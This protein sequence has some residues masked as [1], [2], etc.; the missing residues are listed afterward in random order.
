M[1][2]LAVTMLLSVLALA[3][4]HASEQISIGKAL[5]LV[6]T[7]NPV[8]KQAQDSVT[9]SQARLNGKRSGYYPVISV[10][11]TYAH[12]DPDPFV[13]FP[14]FGTIQFFPENSYDAHASLRQ[15]LWD[16][17]KT[18]S[19]AGAAKYSFEAARKNFELVKTT[20]GYQT[21]QVFYSVLLLKESVLVQQQQIDSLK[22]ALDL[23]TKKVESGSATGFDALTTK[24]KLAEAEDRKI[25]LDNSLR[26]QVISLARLMGVSPAAELE[27]NGDFM[28]KNGDIDET[29]LIAAARQDRLELKISLDS[30]LSAKNQL[31]SARSDNYPTAVAELSYGFKNGYL[32]DLNEIIE[33]RVVAARFEL[34]V[35]N[36]LKTFNSIKESKA[37]YEAAQA[38]TKEI[39]DMVDAEVRQAV[40]DVRAS[41]DKINA[42]DLHVQ[43][44][45]E[46]LKQAK[47][48]Y[49]A[50]V[51]TNLDLLNAETALAQAD[52]AR[53]QALYNYTLSRV[54]LNRAVGADLLRH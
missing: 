18:W 11:G 14:G 12:P 15:V 6:Y 40:S 49:E 50:G 3:R 52:L 17:G 54:A 13:P 36:G 26:K 34:P 10:E 2:K 46:A 47:V 4:L 31:S 1:K 41:I 38:R 22:E 24:V 51:I 29:P 23:T 19:S 45:Q 21:I 9:A 7:N 42:S 48:R 53:V 5:D 44:A 25:D 33:N 28:E 37:N 32:P 30:E 35:F 8:I 16:S 43:L 20:M 39:S 27:I